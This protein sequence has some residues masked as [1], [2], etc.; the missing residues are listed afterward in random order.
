MLRYSPP[1][2]ISDFIDETNF[3]PDFYS[4]FYST[5]CETVIDQTESNKEAEEGEKG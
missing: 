3:I 4:D 1:N 2:I 5:N